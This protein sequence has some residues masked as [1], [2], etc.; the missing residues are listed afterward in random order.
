M[1][2]A[3]F[4]NGKDVGALA[5]QTLYDRLKNSKDMPAEAF[6]PTTMVDATTFKTSGVSCN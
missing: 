5:V 3:L 6:A 4:V 1:K 2:G